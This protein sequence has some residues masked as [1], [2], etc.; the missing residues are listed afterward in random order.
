MQKTIKLLSKQ[1][2]D[3]N[4][5]TLTFAE[6]LQTEHLPGTPAR[7]TA[8]NIIACT[9]TGTEA[10]EECKKFDSGKDYTITIE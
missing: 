5:I 7:Q 8:K 6:D 3:G 1:E 4:K 2:T 9:F 10:V